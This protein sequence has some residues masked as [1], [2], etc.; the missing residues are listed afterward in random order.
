MLRALIASSKQAIYYVIDLAPSCYQ[1]LY[2]PNDF[3][4]HGINHIKL[5]LD[6]SP[7]SLFQGMSLI[8]I[9]IYIALDSPFGHLQL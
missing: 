9:Y 3:K 2:D 6:F 8:Y 4:R 1:G 7:K 5:N